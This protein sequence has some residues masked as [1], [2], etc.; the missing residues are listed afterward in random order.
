[1]KTKLVTLFHQCPG[2]ASQQRLGRTGA[3]LDSIGAGHGLN[4]LGL[5]VERED[6]GAQG[7]LPVFLPRGVR[8]NWRGA[9]SL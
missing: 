1:M 2:A 5:T 7:Q 8:R 4:E 6:P 3:H 9:T